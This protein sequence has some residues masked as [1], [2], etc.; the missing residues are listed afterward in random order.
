M[1]ATST[2][3][4]STDYLP[5]EIGQLRT[6][7]RDKMLPLCDKLCHFLCL[8]G[9]LFELAQETV[10]RQQ[11]EAQCKQFDLDWTRRERDAFR[12][13]LENLTEGW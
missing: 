10:E 1:A 6:E 5:K 2:G 7:I 13:E 3:V 11:L 8:Q 9:R 12:E 4:K